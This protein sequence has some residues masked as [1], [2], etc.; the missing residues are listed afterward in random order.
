MGSAAVERESP[1]LVAGDSL[2]ALP[3]FRAHPKPCAGP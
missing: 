3:A 2:L 1:L